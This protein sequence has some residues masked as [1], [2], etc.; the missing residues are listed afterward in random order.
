MKRLMRTG[1]IAAYWLGWPFLWFY[2]RR[3]QRTRVL[4]LC[5][6]KVLV[7]SG[8]IGHGRWILPGGGLSRGEDPV[9][10]ALR[11]LREEVGISSVRKTD[12]QLLGNALST[13]HGHR[14]T[15]FQFVAEVP[16]ELPIRL[17]WHEI[18]EGRWIDYHQLTPR[19][20]APHV[21]EMLAKY[22]AY[23]MAQHR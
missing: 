19:T 8:W 21:L 7:V 4:L 18:A 23:Q 20:A 12:L 14:Y 17:Q 13:H 6:D 15:Y 3:S 16:Q 1:G 2:F 9:D 11:E 10:G 22:R 5:G